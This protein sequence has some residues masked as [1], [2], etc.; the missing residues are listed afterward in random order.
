MLSAIAGENAVST[1]LAISEKTE[2]LHK[3]AAACIKDAGLK[4]SDINTIF[5]TGGSGR[6]PELLNQKRIAPHQ[7][8]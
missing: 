2:R 6:G 3:V 7:N 1:H 5:F 4:P 8:G